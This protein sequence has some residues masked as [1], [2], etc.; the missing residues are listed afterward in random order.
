[1][2]KKQF[3]QCLAELI[4]PLMG[5]EKNVYKDPKPFI[6]YA[7]ESA[8]AGIIA[9]SLV[10][11]PAYYLVLKPV[12]KKVIARFDE[13]AN[14]FYELNKNRLDKLV[15][16]DGD[17]VV[18]SKEREWLRCLMWNEYQ[19][20]GNFDALQGEYTTTILNGGKRK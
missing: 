10:G 1:M 14:T 9:L 3:I 12:N 15:D 8:V 20:H 11:V 2:T 18:S 16:I 17:G 7:R 19:K 6:Q 13:K 5:G 4:I